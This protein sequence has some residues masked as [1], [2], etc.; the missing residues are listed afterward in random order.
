MKIEIK[1][2]TT[3]KIILDLTL[4][5]Y[6]KSK[7]GLHY[8]K[9]FNDTQCVQVLHHEYIPA[10]MEIVDVSLAFRDDWS[11]TTKEKFDE[12]FE[13]AFQEIKSK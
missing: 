1:K 10:H 11:E 4:P 2:T 9:V 12:I 3:K 13:L 6:V 8:Y 5:I 7:S